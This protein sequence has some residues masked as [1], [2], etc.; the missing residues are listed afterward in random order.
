ME[1]VKKTFQ[2]EFRNRLSRIVVFNSMDETMAELIAGRKLSELGLMLKA[3]KVEL[4]YTE[5]AVQLLKK[6]GILRKL[7]TG[8]SRQSTIE[9]KMHG[10]LF[11]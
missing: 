9:N 3:K 11:P 10:G 6:K 1:E 7:L 5:E 2:P 8:I 4:S